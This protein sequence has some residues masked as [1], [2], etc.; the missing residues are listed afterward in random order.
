[1]QRTN[2]FQSIS[3]NF[4][5]IIRITQWKTTLDIM[6][7]IESIHEDL[8]FIRRIILSYAKLLK[9]TK[10]YNAKARNNNGR[11][12]I[13][14]KFPPFGQTWSYKNNNHHLRL[15]GKWNVLANSWSSNFVSISYYVYNMDT[16]G[17]TSKNGFSVMS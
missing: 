15:E 17:R 12:I 7:S 1:M 14:T 16:S 13:E 5:W 4:M 11:K 10:N 3:T 9:S 6:H 2:I 8:G